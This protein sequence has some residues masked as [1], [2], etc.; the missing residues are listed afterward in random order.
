MCPFVR[1][2]L[3]CESGGGPTALGRLVRIRGWHVGAR[4][5]ADWAGTCLACGK[6]AWLLKSAHRGTIEHAMCGV[7]APRRNGSP[8]VCY[9]RRLGAALGLTKM[10]KAGRMRIP[11]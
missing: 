11:I 2:F 6:G 9:A 5:D 10:E 3:E 1:R 4:R 7:K 8:R